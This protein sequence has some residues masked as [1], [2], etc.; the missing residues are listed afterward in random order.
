MSDNLP[1]VEQALIAYQKKF[2]VQ[3]GQAANE[4][5][6]KLEGLAK[7]EI[8]GRRPKGQKA[9]IGMPPMNRT[10]NLRRSI[11]STTERKGYGTYQAIVGAGMMYARAVEVGAPYNPPT[12]IKGERF[13]FLQ[14]A[15]EKAIKS[16][17]IEKTLRKYLGAK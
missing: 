15:V 7:R 6:L 5:S 11:M 8:K 12:W 2:D 14:P 13:P 9:T 1:E 16:K 17:V 3:I 4:I 10:G